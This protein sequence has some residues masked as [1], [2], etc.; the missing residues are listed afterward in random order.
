[1][2]KRA[3]I[4]A[5]ATITM[6]FALVGWLGTG[7]SAVPTTARPSKQEL[8][9]KTVGDQGTA[10]YAGRPRIRGQGGAGGERAAEPEGTEARGPT[11]AAGSAAGPAAPLAG[12]RPAQCPSQRSGT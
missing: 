7:G 9:K 10:A 12:P 1:M 3:T 11:Q 6:A 4:A 8:A 2:R 5:L